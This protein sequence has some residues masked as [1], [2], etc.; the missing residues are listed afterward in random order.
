M[1]RPNP[2]PPSPPPP[3]AL[4][5]VVSS[6]C[7][8]CHGG[9]CQRCVSVCQ[10]RR[11]QEEF[12]PA[13]GDGSGGQSDWGAPS[14]TGP[15]GLVSKAGGQA[16]S[17]RGSQPPSA[18]RHADARAHTPSISWDAD[19]SQSKSWPAE[20]KAKQSMQPLREFLAGGDK[21]RSRR[22]KRRRRRKRTPR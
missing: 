8:M 22:R 6:L 12:P 19:A 13:G 18:R 16:G 7:N 17:H 14:L 10:R 4:V 9:L 1:L 5:F 11:S 2:P 21:R 15:S 20:D 3:F